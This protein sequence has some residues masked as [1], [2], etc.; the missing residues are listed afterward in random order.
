[1]LKGGKK[2]KKSI[3][4]AELNRTKQKKIESLLTILKLNRNSSVRFKTI[5]FDSVW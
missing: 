5:Q 4:T 1:M 2:T 3:R